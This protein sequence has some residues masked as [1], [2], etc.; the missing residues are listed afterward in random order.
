MTALADTMSTKTTSS[1]DESNNETAVAVG[2]DE[3][4]VDADEDV[5]SAVVRCADCT[6]KVRSGPKIDD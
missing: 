1:I 3:R 4:V 2:T 5:D 6:D